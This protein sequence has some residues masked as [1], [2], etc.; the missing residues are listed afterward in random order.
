MGILKGFMF[1]LLLFTT[2]GVINVGKLPLL[3]RL[4]MNR[5]CITHM[6]LGLADTGLIWKVHC[7]GIP[8][9]RGRLDTVVNRGTVS[10]HVHKVMGGNHFS[11][12]TKDQSEL[13]LY[14]ITKSA[15]CTTCSI[16]T[17]DNSNY[18]H[19]DL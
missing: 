12:G 2:L 4:E 13:E 16:H 17:I 5:T 11:A 1:C 3:N 18:W 8:V 10:S 14:E 15:S 7:S 19:P 9:Y 6:L